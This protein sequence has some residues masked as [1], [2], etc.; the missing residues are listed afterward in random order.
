MDDG[1]R[2]GLLGTGGAE[3]SSL[4]FETNL[5]LYIILKKLFV[6]Y[7]LYPRAFSN[8]IHPY[9]VTVL[10]KLF[11]NTDK[12]QVAHYFFQEFLA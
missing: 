4:L 5:S 12:I 10:K 2:K 9:A 8:N 1:R 3:T 7:R 11:Q 6:R